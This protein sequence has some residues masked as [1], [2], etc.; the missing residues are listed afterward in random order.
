VE[1]DDLTEPVTDAARA[2]LDG[3][4]ILS[5]DLAK[6][7]HYPAIDVLSSISRLMPDIVDPRQKEY[8]GKFVE[9]LACYKKLEDMINLGMYQE[10]SNPQ[11]DYAVSM[12][13]KLNAF[14]RQGMDEKRDFSDSLQGLFCLF[15]RIETDRADDR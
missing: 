10:G 13:E 4:I 9:T 2:I 6:E 14:L 1:G 5:R 11:V 7:N 3:H 8:A 12:I 15:D